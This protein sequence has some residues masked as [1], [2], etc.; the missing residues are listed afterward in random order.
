MYNA[1]QDELKRCFY[2]VVISAA[3]V[4]DWSPERSYD[5]KLPTKSMP[6]FTLKLRAT[7]KLVESVKRVSSG[8]FSVVF[9]AVY[10]LS[11]EDAVNQGYEKLLE[12]DADMIVVN[13]VGKEGSG[14]MVDTNEVYVID[15]ERSV[16]HV[17]LSPKPVVAER[18]LDLVVKKLKKSNLR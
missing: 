15:K 5:Y 17:P 12:A 8:S 6:E 14:F 10:K 9:K 18:I 7:P 2:D 4:S 11:V 16:V 3:A 13:D 1:L